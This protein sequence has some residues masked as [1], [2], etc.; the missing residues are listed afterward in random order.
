MI[1]RAGLAARALRFG[2]RPMRILVTALVLAACGS[3]TGPLIPTPTSLI[4][5]AE[6]PTQTVNPV[7]ETAEAA[8]ASP[9]LGDVCAL[10]SSDE[11]AA[12][13]GAS[14]LATSP[15]EEPDDIGGGTLHFCT[16]LGS[17]AA[18]VLSVAETASADAAR[19]SAEAGVARMQA[20]DLAATTASEPGLGDGATW[21][22]TPNA[23]GY[24]VIT[25]NRVFSVSLGG[26]AIGD[27][28]S[29][30]AAL[31]ALALKLVD[32]L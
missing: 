4:G 12:V 6:S 10:I 24:T 11:A 3:A 13:L 30:R 8:A 20:E 5:G 28:A 14:P 16:Y 2:I 27:P 7:P 19:Q 1:G 26:Q 15:G 32:R 9:P 21:V 18:L 25:G 22:V 31:L 17:G 29:H 23:A